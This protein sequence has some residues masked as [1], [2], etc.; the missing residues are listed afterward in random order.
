MT[1][2]LGKRTTAILA[3][4]ALAFSVIVPLS[5]PKAF[6]APNCHKAEVGDYQAKIG[7]VVSDFTAEIKN[8]GSYGYGIHNGRVYSPALDSIVPG[9]GEGREIDRIIEGSKYSLEDILG[10][11]ADRK[12][13]S[14]LIRNEDGT[15]TSDATVNID[16]PKKTVDEAKLKEVITGELAEFLEKNP[17]EIC[18]G[19]NDT[20]PG[21]NPKPGCHK[22]E[23]S[24]YKEKIEQEVEKI[25][26][27]KRENSYSWS[28]LL[29]N[30]IVPAF[31]AELELTDEQTEQV[32]GEGATAV[33]LGV[34][35]IDDPS[36]PKVPTDHDWLRISRIH[37]EHATKFDRAAMTKIITDKVSEFLEKNPQE[38]CEEGTDP[39]PGTTEPTTEP[40]KPGDNPKPGDD[41]KPG[42][43]AKPDTDAKSGESTKDGKNTS[44]D[45]NNGSQAAPEEGATDAGGLAT[46][47]AVGLIALGVAVLLVGSGAAL[48]ICRRKQANV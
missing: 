2:R 11:G 12:M 33:A 43:T 42:D 19:G 48:A 31:K 45:A 47:G 9:F 15:T 36:V 35:T 34:P 26:K 25:D 28:G 40:T 1:S 23:I 3:F 18:E 44:S 10:E 7:K 29:L 32:F 38:I 14:G 30:N 24:D 6:S 27:S 8:K 13:M 41:T 17:Q 4:I 22:A 5:I 39:K 37:I 16:S 21:D 20:K 46:T